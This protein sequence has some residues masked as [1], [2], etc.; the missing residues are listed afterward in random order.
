MACERCGYKNPKGLINAITDA[1]RTITV[2]A[3]C[4]AEMYCFD[5]LQFE[6]NLNFKDDITGLPGAVKYQAIDECY[7]LEKETMYRLIARNL[8]PEEYFA[9]V[10]LYGTEYFLLHDDFYTEDGVAIQPMDD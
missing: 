5:E 2:C 1:K 8:K 7:F 3:N 4:L 10:E 6:N 9:L